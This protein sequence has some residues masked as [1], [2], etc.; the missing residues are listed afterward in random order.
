VIKVAYNTF[1]EIV[2][3][4]LGIWVFKDDK[5]P[6]NTKFH[7]NCRCKT[8]PLSHMVMRQRQAKKLKNAV[9]AKVKDKS[10]SELAKTLD[11]L[12]VPLNAE[13]VNLVINV[14]I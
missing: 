9:R 2:P 10:V 8:E 1:G 4:K 5:K 7:Y 14:D 13:N 6:K 12:D 3:N 11:G